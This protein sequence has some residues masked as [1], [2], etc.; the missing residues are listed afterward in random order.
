MKVV[1]ASDD[2][3]A[4]TRIN[5]SNVAI[6]PV[7]AAFVGRDAIR[8][9]QFGAVEGARLSVP[10]NRGESILYPYISKHSEAGFSEH[11]R[12]GR[13]AITFNVD[14]VSSQSGMISPGDNVDLL[15]TL[16]DG[17]DAV[18]FPLLQ[19]VPILATGNRME[20]E[21]NDANAGRF[22]TVTMEVSPLD[23]AR[24]THARAA[25]TLTVVVRGPGDDAQISNERI[26]RA[27]LLGNA[28]NR[29]GPAHPEIILGG[30]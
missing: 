24:I 18:T 23:A 13:R 6:R 4:G 8:P 3:Q 16:N 21:R 7:P 20:G 11:I 27:S 19:N 30:K 22:R 5:R 9:E 28:R 25:G 2:I 26:S 12:S 10:V 14:D 17:T 29:K 15:V 1:V